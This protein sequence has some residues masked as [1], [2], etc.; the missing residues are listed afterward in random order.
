MIPFDHS[1]DDPFADSP[2]EGVGPNVWANVVGTL[3]MEAGSIVSS[4]AVTWDG[5]SWRAERRSPVDPEQYDRAAWS[6]EITLDEPEPPRS[7]YVATPEG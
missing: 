6:G 2:P 4:V 7:G 1:T 5:G 3:A